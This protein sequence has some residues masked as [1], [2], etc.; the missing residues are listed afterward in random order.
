MH[1]VTC[2]PPSAKAFSFERLKSSGNKKSVMWWAMMWPPSCHVGLL[3][4][5]ATL[6]TIPLN[7]MKTT[8][9]INF[10]PA[11]HIPFS[12]LPTCLLDVITVSWGAKEDV[13]LQGPKPSLEQ[14]KI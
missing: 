1:V 6:K 5:T 9:R 7:L 12:V 14:P 11:A 13:E 4:S 2:F 8:G 3:L 10:L